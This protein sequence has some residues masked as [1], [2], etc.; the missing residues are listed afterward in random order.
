MV[1]VKIEST[2]QFDVLSMPHDLQMNRVLPLV[3]WAV[4]VYKAR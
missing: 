1:V 2:V 4:V 3:Q